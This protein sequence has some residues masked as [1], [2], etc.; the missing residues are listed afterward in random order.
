MRIKIRDL[1]DSQEILSGTLAGKRLFGTLVASTPL[2]D[3]PELVFLDFTGIQIATASFLREGII[4]FRD[5]TRSSNK[6]AYPVLANASP[7]VVDEFEFF[8]R[9]RI[10][11]FWSCKLDD[12]NAVSE[13]K[14]LGELDAT[15]KE[16][17]A[18]I[19]ELGG[20]ASAP[21]LAARSAGNSAIGSTAWNNRLA[22]L[23]DKGL[24]IESRVGKT[25]EFSPLLGRA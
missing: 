19:E 7:Q 18:L 22:S 13:E 15:Q 25:K 1:T 20:K 11:A 9:Q 16:T 2:F 4:A 3:K 6:N 17:F 5:Y 14:I 23:S 24:V 12:S 10:D 21:D 8:L